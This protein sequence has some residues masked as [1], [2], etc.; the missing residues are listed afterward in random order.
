[1]RAREAFR[2]QCCYCNYT[3]LPWQ[4]WLSQFLLGLDIADP[5][6]PPSTNAFQ[7]P[8][9]NNSLF[10]IYCTLKSMR[11]VKMYRL[12]GSFQLLYD[13]LQIP[14]KAFSHFQSRYS[15]QNESMKHSSFFF[16]FFPYKSWVLVY[17]LVSH[18]SYRQHNF[19]NW[20]VRVSTRDSKL[21]VAGNVLLFPLTGH[22]QEWIAIRKYTT[23]LPFKTH[24]TTLS[25]FT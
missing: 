7:R 13:T 5:S 16:L 2:W 15:K 14:K 10:F 20:N 11:Y 4:Y 24:C 9:C 22:L 19:I 18:A 8:S 23:V 21:Y 3:R 12:H 25:S 6:G 1:M 17:H